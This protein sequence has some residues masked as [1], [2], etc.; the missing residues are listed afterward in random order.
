MGFDGPFP[1]GRFGGGTVTSSA[2]VEGAEAEAFV[3]DICI[4]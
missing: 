3:I 1:A 4:N 2:G